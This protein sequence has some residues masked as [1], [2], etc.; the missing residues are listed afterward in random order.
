MKKI[1]FAFTILLATS[2]IAQKDT[3]VELEESKMKQ[4][5]LY[6][7]KDVA[8]AAMYNIIAIQGP[9]STYKDSLAYLYFNK[10]NYIS[11]F[12]VTKDILDRKPDNIEL[13]EMSA[14]SLESVG[15]KDKAIELYEK[16]I[17]LSNKSFHAYK[18]ASLQYEINKLDE[19][20]VSIK[21]ADQLPN[22]DTLNISFQVNA[23]Y[24]QNVKLKASIAYLEGL[25]AI[26]LEKKPEAKLAFGRAIKLFPDFVLAKGQLE[27]LNEK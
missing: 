12:L 11:C 10:R 6:G 23:N 13:L 3:K 8:T 25:I 4:A 21:K 1:I 2:A 18:V 14:I 16:L 24:S 17:V 27:S 9:E 7:D 5:L 22:D 26:R 20:F 15:A 19:A